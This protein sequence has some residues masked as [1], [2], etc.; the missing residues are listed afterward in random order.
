MTA[1]LFPS[2]F[3][4]VS[5]F[6]EIEVRFGPSR[7]SNSVYV[8]RRLVAVLLLVGFISL[9]GLGVRTVLADRGGVPASTPA[10]RPASSPAA[11]G[12][13]LAVPAAMP[14]GGQAAQAA[15]ATLV[16]PVTP[17]ALSYVVQPGDTLWSL[18]Q[19][20]HGAHSLS[21]YVDA[22]VHANG[23]ATVRSGQVLRLP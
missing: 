11:A 4:E 1:T 19:R 12:A 14:A 10:I 2:G 23:G 18:A 8:R 3:G 22:L 15:T 16:A 21:S 17:V 5:G 13:A 7:S 20:F 9:V 6:G